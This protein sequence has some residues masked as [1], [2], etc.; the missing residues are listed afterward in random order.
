MGKLDSQ[1]ERVG[2]APEP[3][4]DVDVYLGVD[5]SDQIEALQAQIDE[6][7]RVAGQ[8][9]SRKAVVDDLEKQI[10]DLEAQNADALVTL[11]FT[12][13]PGDKYADLTGRHSPRLDSPLDLNAH[14][15]VD[16]VVKAAAAL[17]GAEVDGDTVTPL[18]AAQVEKLWPLLSG[19]D[20]GLIRD[21]VLML[22][23]IGP[24]QMVINAKKAR[25]SSTPS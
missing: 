6:R 16:E 2:A 15:N 25:L 14:Y 19:H 17:S 3:F 20:V 13:L 4:Y 1:L 7:K 12:K 22:N 8:R 5:V 21:V 9:Q 11:R 23:D 10:A 18:T 24:R